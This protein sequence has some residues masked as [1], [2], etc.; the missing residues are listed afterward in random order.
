MAKTIKKQKGFTLIEL[1]VVMG[2]LAVL[3]AAVLIAINPDRQFK[4]ARDSQRRNDVLTILNAVQQNI[5][6]NKGTFTGGTLGATALT[7]AKP[8]VAG[9]SIDICD[10]LAPT[11][12]SILPSDPN[13]S[14]PNGV[15]D[16]TADYNTGYT[17]SQTGGRITVAASA[18]TVGV[19]PISVTR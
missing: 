18:E 14:N 12:T 13:S 6:D 9:T 19:D 3:L 11:Y 10:D 17:I 7:I 2:I 4:Q 5:A 1:L 8:A 15:V 16:C